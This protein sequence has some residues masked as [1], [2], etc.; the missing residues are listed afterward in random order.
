M[1][2]LDRRG[3]WEGKLNLGRG[4]CAKLFLRDNY[5]E[6]YASVELR[7][8]RMHSSVLGGRGGLAEIVRKKER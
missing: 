5:S 6:G 2:N 3:K 7:D 8:Q 1:L 4:G